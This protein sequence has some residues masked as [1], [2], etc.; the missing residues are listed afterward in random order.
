MSLYHLLFALIIGCDTQN[1]AQ[2]SSCSLSI[3]TS[4]PHWYAGSENELNITPSTTRWDTLIT[5]NGQTIETVDVTRINCE[6]CDQCKE[7]FLCVGCN[8]CDACDQLCKLNCEE[9]TTVQV[10]EIMPGTYTVLAQNLYGMS[11]TLDLEILS[12]PSEDTASE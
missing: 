5:I 4:E 3:S 9:T 6:E 1:V 10:P 7:D 8:D 12:S 11:E 2:G